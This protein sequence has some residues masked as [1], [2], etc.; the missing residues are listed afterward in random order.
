MAHLS[1]EPAGEIISGDAFASL[2]I[3]EMALI[4]KALKGTHPAGGD[5]EAPPWREQNNDY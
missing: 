1:Y 3:V 5:S 4:R 2:N